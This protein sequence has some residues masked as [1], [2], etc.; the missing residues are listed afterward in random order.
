M[1][2]LLSLAAASAACS[3]S[4]EAG[5]GG[6]TGTGG[7]T[8]TTSVGGT[9]GTSG[10]TGTGGTP[11]VD[12]KTLVTT[13]LNAM[14]VNKDV[15][16][17][18]TYFTAEFLQHN[19]NQPSGSGPLK[20]SVNYLATLASYKYDLFRAIAA[21]DLVMTHSRF[22]GA[23]GPGTSQIAFDLFRV[24]A[25]K[26]AEHWNCEQAEMLDANGKPVPN[27]SGHTMADGPTMIQDQ[28][29]T[30]TN[31][32]AVQAFIDTVLVQGQF[33]KVGG[34]FAGDGSTYIQHNPH[35]G[36]GLAAFGAFLGQ[37]GPLAYTKI[38]KVVAE[39]DFVVSQSEG[40]LGA[41]PNKQHQVFYDMF[42][43]EKDAADTNKPKIAEHWDCIWPY[44]DATMTKSGLPML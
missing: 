15:S 26:I 34:W 33:N 2:S 17:V 29:S 39:G 31:K 1:L 13:A 24:Q 25:G 37:A 21:D 23:M 27:A 40:F 36:D 6:S 10:T 8:S 4:G 44:V 38:G 18:D 41:D 9:T 14:F 5:S 7:T 32:A 11:P 20:D 3:S 22:A 30:A 28:A 16:A 42:R 12:N 43:M 35:V 19:P